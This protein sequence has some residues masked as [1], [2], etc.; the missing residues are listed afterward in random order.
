MLTETQKELIE[1]YSNKHINPEASQTQPSF[2]KVFYFLL[3]QPRLNKPEEKDDRQ[4][5][6]PHSIKTGTFTQHT[7]L[8]TYDTQRKDICHVI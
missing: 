7:D 5:A 2:L 1:N 6:T 4:P 8:Q 3:V